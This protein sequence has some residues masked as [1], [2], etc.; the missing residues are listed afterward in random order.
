LQFQ[1]EEIK[2]SNATPSQTTFC[3]RTDDLC[4]E[5][6]PFSLVVVDGGVIEYRS[7]SIKI[8]LEPYESVILRAE[9]TPCKPGMF[10]VDVPIFL[11]GYNDGTVYN[12]IHLSG[13]MKKPTITV[14][15]NEVHFPPIPLEVGSEVTLHITAENYQQQD[16]IY[17][18]IWEIVNEKKTLSETLHFKWLEEPYID[19]ESDVQNFSIRIW[20]Q[21]SIPVALR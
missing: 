13:E 21:S 19:G 20:F 10:D 11:K 14:D 4:Q 16:V 18:Q 5:N 8:D 7:K 6:S 2:I 3:F 12:Y 9:F 17:A 1:S 15:A